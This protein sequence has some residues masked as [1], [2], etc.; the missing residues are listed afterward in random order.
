MSIQNP[1]R[2]GDKLFLLHREIIVLNVYALFSLV[3]VRYLNEIKE[4]SV[5]ICAL[6]P[7][8]NYTNF[9]SLNIFKG[10]MQ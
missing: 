2:I 5:D 3:T 10:K 4:F 9:I 8:P 6:S 7:I 1:P